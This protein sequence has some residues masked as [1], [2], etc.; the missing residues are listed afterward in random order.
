MPKQIKVSFAN[1]DHEAWLVENDSNTYIPPQRVTDKID[2]QEYIVASLSIGPVGYLRLSYFWSFIPFIDIIAV[3]EPYRYK[4]VGR[5]LLTFL[6][7]H[8]RKQDQ[9]FILSSSQAD[10][11]EP[12]AWHRHVG[13]IDAGA[14]LNLE[15]LQKV[16]EVLFV[17]RLDSF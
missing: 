15:P 14:L 8:A 4:G 7:N 17:K 10:E 2:R 5:A 1:K 12:Q 16:T 6:E 3:K 9:K 13:F 11:A